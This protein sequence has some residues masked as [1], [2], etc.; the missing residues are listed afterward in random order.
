M[1]TP[2][3]MW[4]WDGIPNVWETDNMIP[5]ASNPTVQ[6][7]NAVAETGRDVL[8]VQRQLADLEEKVDAILAKLS[9]PSP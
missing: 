8:R 7:L 9:S 3:D 5:P 2:A 4:K 6:G 1:P